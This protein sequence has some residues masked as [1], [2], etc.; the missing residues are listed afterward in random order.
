MSVSLIKIDK[1]EPEY[2][3]V[4]LLDIT[5]RRRAQS[6]IEESDIAKRKNENMYR[7]IAEYSSDLISRHRTDGI[8]LYVSPACKALL[9]YETEELLG[10]QSYRT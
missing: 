9:G 4:Q 1:E 8:Y 7:M 3:L 5:T 6:I 10:R 2:C